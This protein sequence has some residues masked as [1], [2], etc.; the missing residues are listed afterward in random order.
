MSSISY[1]G[2]MEL[3]SEVRDMSPRTGRPTDCRKDH[4]IKVRIDDE[5]HKELLQYCEKQGITKAEAIRQG[6]RLVLQEK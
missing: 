6:I 4:D 5:T 3:K 1:N 2:F